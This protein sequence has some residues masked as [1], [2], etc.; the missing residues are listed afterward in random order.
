MLTREEQDFL[1]R[2]NAPEADT[3]E[4]SESAA[5]RKERKLLFL[6]NI[7]NGVFML[8]AVLAMAG[9]GY[10]MYKDNEHIHTVSIGIGIVAVL[11]KMVEASLRM[12]NMLKKP[13]GMKQRRR[14]R[15][16]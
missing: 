9:I 12:S 3:Q 11:I 7:L 16:K 8:L 15:H 6:R 13:Q 1:E 10:A 14:T 4:S 5:K 2:L